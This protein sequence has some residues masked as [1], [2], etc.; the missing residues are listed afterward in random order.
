MSIER[1]AQIT[2]AIDAAELS[3]A[4]QERPGAPTGWRDIVST[5]MAVG[6]GGIVGANVRWQVSEW[7]A[8][9]W[10]SSF[11]WGTF[12]INISGSFVLGLYLT[13]AA[14]RL[15]GRPLTRLFVATGVIGAYTTF[16]T[17][18]YESARLI[19]HGHAVTA[20]AY[21]AASL[22]VG[23]SAAAAGIMAGRAR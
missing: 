8:R 7:S 15:V 5:A 10:P 19:E 17:F 12:L 4:P 11:P 3:D 2:A 22:A 1:E 13:I 14:E 20:A 16:S 18:V 9:H 6:I 23:L 21:V